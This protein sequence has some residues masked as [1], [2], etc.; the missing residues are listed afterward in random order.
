MEGGGAIFNKNEK[1]NKKIRLRKAVGRQPRQ[2]ARLE[3]IQV[4]YILQARERERERE[5]GRERGR[6]SEKERKYARARERE[7]VCGKAKNGG[8]HGGGGVAMLEHAI[9][10]N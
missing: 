6:E 9:A 1:M 7:I 2:R 4:T 8:Q 5:T 10:L 3:Y